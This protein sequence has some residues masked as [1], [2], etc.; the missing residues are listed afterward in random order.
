MSKY[1]QLTTT[2]ENIQY[3]YDIVIN[4]INEYETRICKVITE[5]F[6]NK[7]LEKIK[8][9]TKKGK[10]SMKVQLFYIDEYNYFF[11]EFNHEYWSLI[12]WMKLYKKKY[13]NSIITEAFNLIN[14]IYGMREMN[15]EKYSYNFTYEYSV[16]GDDYMTFEG[17]PTIKYKFLDKNIFQERKNLCLGMYMASSKQI[18]K[19]LATYFSQIATTIE[20]SENTSW[21]YLTFNW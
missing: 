14:K 11:K 19:T 4:L 7:C 3:I 20:Y 16:D 8:T 1:V 6:A 10:K 13:D 9:K 5:K 18:K 15:A 17:P 2:E 12:N 21:I